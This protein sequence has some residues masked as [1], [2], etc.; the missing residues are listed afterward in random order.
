MIE[1]FYLWYNEIVDHVNI[2]GTKMN[3]LKIIQS[4]EPVFIE[5]GKLASRLRDGAEI[6]TKLGSGIKEIDVVT[7]ADLA[8]Q[9][10]VLQKML[11]TDLVKCELVAEEDT[12]SRIKFAKKSDTVITLDPIDGTHNYV[13]GQKLYSIIVTL[14]NKKSPIYTFMYFPEVA[15]GLR[16]LGLEISFFGDEPKGEIIATDPKKV[17][18]YTNYKGSTDPRKTI[19][20]LYIKLA[21][22]GYKFKQKE[23][24]GKMLG[25]VLF[26]ITGVTGGIFIENPSAVDGLVCLHY[27]L[28]KKYKIWNHIDISVPSPSELG[29]TDE[30]KGY[31]I[32]LR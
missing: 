16:I 15:W 13:T 14:H 24:L 1:L 6:G 11:E 28:A 7:S 25:P 31:Y 8:V 2:E 19:P 21:N 29:G 22:E 26:F 32:V 30:Y 20:D 4:L 9:E 18:G 27:G 3:I 23:N 10:F 5:A 17:I 12:P